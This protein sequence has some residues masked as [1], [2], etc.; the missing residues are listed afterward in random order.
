MRSPW[1][2]DLVKRGSVSPA[3]RDEIYADC[4]ELLKQASD[5][6]SSP[7]YAALLNKAKPYVYAAGAALAGAGI[8]MLP[9]MRD[10]KEV[11]QT[12]DD[13]VKN[14]AEV[15]SHPDMAEHRDVAGARFDEITNLAP[16]VARNRAF[17]ERLV[18]ARLHSGLTDHDAE[19]LSLLQAHYTPRA[20]MQK[21]LQ[22]KKAADAGERMA[23]VYLLI[24]QAAPVEAA[25]TL[26]RTLAKAMIAPAV[27]GAMSTLV[28]LGNVL[29]DLRSKSNLKASLQASFE[30]ALR[31]SDPDKEPLHQNKEKAL[32]AF[33]ALVHFA[34]HVAA[35]P[36]AARSFMNRVVSYN[37]GIDASSVKELSDIEKNMKITRSESPFFS[38]AATGSSVFGLADVTSTTIK[39]SLLPIQHEVTRDIAAARGLP[40]SN[41]SFEAPAPDPRKQQPFRALGV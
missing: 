21:K 13:I 28:G 40:Y 8:Y 1:L 37:Q 35:E 17:M 22:E 15:L 29:R 39:G 3:A 2:E 27:I 34:P 12:M 7:E 4:G 30:E 41:R 16:S 10:A 14:R 26:G 25:E 18:K 24:K 31:M 19:S 6:R 9:K 32:Q 11:Q 38:G 33:R 20:G 5:V 23:D 36:Q